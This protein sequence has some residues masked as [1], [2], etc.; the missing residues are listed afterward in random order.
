LVH[1]IDLV[2]DQLLAHRA[3]QPDEVHLRED[4]LSEPESAEEEVHLV[5][6]AKDGL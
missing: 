5:L 2:L 1:D 3:V 4:A 6:E